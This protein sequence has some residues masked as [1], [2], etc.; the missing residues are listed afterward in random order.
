MVVLNLT[1]ESEFRKKNLRTSMHFLVVFQ[2]LFPKDATVSKINQYVLILQ[3][4]PI[5][6]SCCLHLDISPAPITPWKA[7]SPVLIIT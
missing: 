1:A 4:I 5:L 7:I 3:V 6:F 2:P